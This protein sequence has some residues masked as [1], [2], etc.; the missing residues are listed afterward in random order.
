MTA[1]RER[2]A[3]TFD[4]SADL[5]DEVR[6]G[7][8]EALFDDIE[9]LAGLA[10]G[11]RVFEIGAGT[12]KATVPLARRGYR[13]TALE[14]GPSLAAVARRNLAPYPEVELIES[15]FEAWPLEAGAF[16]LVA[17][18]TSF[19]WVDPAVRYSK[20]ADA[21]HP[22]GCLAIFWHYHVAIPGEDTFFDVSQDLHRQYGYPRELVGSP[23]EA[24]AVPAEVP[25][26]ALG[27]G[28]FEAVAVRHYP[29]S[30]R[31]T[32]ER[33]L[34]LLRTFSGYLDLPDERREPLLAGL[35]ALIDSDFGGAITKRYVTVLQ[36]LRR[37]DS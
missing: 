26:E 34:K 11:A 21:L 35:G 12:G 33:Y 30:E 14:P 10:R 18:A 24:S 25:Q 9:R 31:I 2:L 23:P 8:P 22:G 6:P 15:G 17:A 29:W 27:S 3:A 16:G 32:S 28:L 19:D 5:Y 4:R 20:A 36:L 7:Y 37:V 1:D 13:V